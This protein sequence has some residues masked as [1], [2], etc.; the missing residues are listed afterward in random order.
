MME[1]DATRAKMDQVLHQRD[2]RESI[3]G[4]LRLSAGLPLCQ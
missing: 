2:Q 1:A 4:K 3:L